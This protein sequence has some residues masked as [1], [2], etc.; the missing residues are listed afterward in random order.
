MPSPE[1]RSGPQERRVLEAL[2]TLGG[3]GSSADVNASLNMRP[4]ELHRIL[5]RCVERE[6]ITREPHPRRDQPRAPQ[7]LF[8]VTAAGRA[9]LAE[10]G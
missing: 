9:R 6:L 4:T 7:L 8:T 10:R 1:P 2:V 5:S 3:S